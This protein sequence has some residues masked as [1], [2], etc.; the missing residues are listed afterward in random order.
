[1]GGKINIAVTG[2]EGFVG[3][4]LCVRLSELDDIEHSPLT[5]ETTAEAYQSA[6]D[7]A[8]LVIHLAGVN[9]PD[10]PADYSGNVDA[11]S[12]LA[13]AIERSG[14]SMGVVFSSS[15]KAVDD[16]PYGR[17]KKQAED[18][19]LSL[20][21][22]QGVDTLIMRLPNVFGKW[23][24]P[25]YN[26]A[27]ATFCHN[28]A[29]GLPVQVNDPLAPL[30]LIY[31]DDLVDQLV[32]IIREKN[33]KTGFYEVDEVFDTTVG[34][35]ADLI[36][37][38]H[39]QRKACSIDNVGVG[40][41]RALYATYISYLPPVDFSYE[42]VSHGDPRGSFSEVVRTPE[43]GQFSYFNAHP[44]VTRGGHYHHTKSEKFLVVHGRA[45]FKFRHILTDAVHQIETSADKPVVVDTIPGTRRAYDSR[46]NTRTKSSS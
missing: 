36:Q 13:I 40:L 21:Q 5:R 12:N 9:R 19:F 43:A 44:G 14:R 1:M 38:F 45:L 32:N 4:N 15:V 26:S 41:T 10:N 2:A 30:S 3:K 37:K 33:L 25:N 24:K 39:D 18:Q 42:L 29:R 6:I 34:A 20:A 11:A 16:T 22:E 27:V 7:H 35:V 23:C 17:S 31:I 46:R 8:D 28:I